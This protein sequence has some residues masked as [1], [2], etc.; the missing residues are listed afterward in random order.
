MIIIILK[1]PVSLN[2]TDNKLPLVFHDT[3]FCFIVITDLQ[4]ELFPP[5]ELYYL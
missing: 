3:L 1:S 5:T 2:K 4:V